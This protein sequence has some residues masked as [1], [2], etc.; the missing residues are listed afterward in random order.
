MIALRRKSRQKNDEDERPSI[1]SFVACRHC[2]ETIPVRNVE[3]LADEFAVRCTRC[4]RR[5]FLTRAD[6]Q[7]SRRT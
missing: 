5:S 7:Q 3:N 1:L 4:H 2:G 6:V